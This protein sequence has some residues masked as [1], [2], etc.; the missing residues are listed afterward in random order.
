[1]IATPAAR[2]VSAPNDDDAG[3]YLATVTDRDNVVAAAFHGASG[4]ILLTAAPEPAVTSPGISR[5]EAG[6]R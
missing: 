3:I 5:V 6:I 1:M 4:G 2:M